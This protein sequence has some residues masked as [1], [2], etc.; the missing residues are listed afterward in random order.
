M[1]NDASRNHRLLNTN[2]TLRFENFSDE[3]LV[4]AVLEAPETI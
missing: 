1:D 4:R 2:S 3:L